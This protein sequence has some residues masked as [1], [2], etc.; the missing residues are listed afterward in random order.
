MLAF[1][2]VQQSCK[3]IRQALFSPLHRWSE[4]SM[5]L[6]KSTHPA[7]RTGSDMRTS[8]ALT[9]A[10]NAIRAPWGGCKTVVRACQGKT[11]SSVGVGSGNL[12]ILK[13][14]DCCKDL[15]LHQCA[16]E[17]VTAEKHHCTWSICSVCLWNRQLT[18]WKP[19]FQK[20]VTFRRWCL[21]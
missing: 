18:A 5:T 4:G 16:G 8:D 2:I 7:C 14:A 10:L 19:G 12:G 3:V 1:D 9:V 20:S 13:R 21:M 6:T 11:Q 17:C 15:P